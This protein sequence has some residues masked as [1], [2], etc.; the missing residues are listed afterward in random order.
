MS[1]KLSVELS[2]GLGNRLFQIGAMYGLA[3]K[4]GRVPVITTHE[5]QSNMHDGQTTDFY[6]QLFPIIP[7]MQLKQMSKLVIH[8]PFD[9]AS[10]YMQHIIKI[11]SDSTVD[12]VCLRGYF[13]TEKYFKDYK[14][15][16][17]QLF[18]PPRCITGHIRETYPNVKQSYF[19]HNR[20]YTFPGENTKF[21]TS[22][23][24]AKY[25]DRALELLPVPPT[26]ILTDNI[27]LNKQF[28][29][30]KKLPPDTVIVQENTLVSLYIMSMC[31]G[32]ICS[33][34][35]FSWWGSYLHGRGETSEGE[36]V[37]MPY[38]W[39]NMNDKGETIDVSDLFPDYV[40]VVT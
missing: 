35:S 20:T 24:H 28:Q 40:T 29:Y 14:A 9:K 25:F 31:K 10:T 15:E 11:I 2:G 39:Y 18:A 21:H 36:V 16:I 27:E 12:I 32:G 26:L 17:L 8:E 5:S 30:M 6:L 22:D 13:Q 4:T 37:T 1:K 23:Y 19:L 34:S 7:P 33:N 3:K 38:R